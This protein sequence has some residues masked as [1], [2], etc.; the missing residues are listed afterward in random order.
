M[1]DSVDGSYE[2]SSLIF[3]ENGKRVQKI[4]CLLELVGSS[5]FNFLPTS[6]V[7]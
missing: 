2:M 6:A 7:C 4:C 1:Y 3:H 5:M